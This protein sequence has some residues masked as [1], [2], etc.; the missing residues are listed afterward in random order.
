CGHRATL[1]FRLG[2]VPCLWIGLRGPGQVP[3]VIIDPEPGRSPH[4]WSGTALE[5][6]SHFDL[7]L[8]L[9]TGMG[10]AGS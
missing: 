1:T 5:S 6:G 7:Q 9:H 10:R 2:E 3:T 4:Y 8:L